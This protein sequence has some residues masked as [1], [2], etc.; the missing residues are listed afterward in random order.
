MKIQVIIGSTRQGRQSDKLAKWVE[1]QANKN[2]TE[3]EIVDLLDYNLPMFN[4]PISP[5][6]N[7]D[8]K[9]ETVVKKWLDKISEAEG[10]VV[11]TPEYNRSITAVL[12]NAL[13][14]IGFQLQ[15]KPVAI[16]AH[17]TSGGAQAVSHLR[18]IIPGLLA[19]T[20]PQAVY[21]THR[22]GE[23]LDDSGTL[24]KELSNNPYGPQAALQNT[25]TSLVWYVD[26]LS[27][28]RNNS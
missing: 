21:F 10:Y 23:V 27:A 6:Y 4:E 8:R 7:P 13:D 19:V 28:A 22:L 16:V 9:S 11:V 24:N 12:K 3:I 26:A 25:L 20:V 5:Q 17:G 2:G 1:D 14:Y 15:N 18:G